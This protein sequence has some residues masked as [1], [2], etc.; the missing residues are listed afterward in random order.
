LWKSVLCQ[1]PL[2]QE[3]MGVNDRK[4]KKAKMPRTTQRGRLL[5][6]D[7]TTGRRRSSAAAPMHQP[8]AAMKKE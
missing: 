6:V 2:V 3:I 1:I 4:K 5:S 8:P 7:S